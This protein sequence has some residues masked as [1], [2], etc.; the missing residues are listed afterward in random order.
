MSRESSIAPRFSSS[1]VGPWVAGI[2]SLQH[3]TLVPTL[4][5]SEE[6]IEEMQPGM[7]REWIPFSATKQ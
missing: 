7:E 2:G 5:V 1:N 6:Q 4:V 3:W